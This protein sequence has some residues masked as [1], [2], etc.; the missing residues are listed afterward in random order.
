MT[1]EVTYFA[2]VAGSSVPP[3]MAAAPRRTRPPT[4][5]NR[6]APVIAP[7]LMKSRLVLTGVL[8]SC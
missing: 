2:T 5:K 6:P 7:T 8:L 3:G 4:G 1:S